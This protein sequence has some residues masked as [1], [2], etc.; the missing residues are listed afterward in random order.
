MYNNIK[1]F[2]FLKSK[3]FE[4]LALSR[5][6]SEEREK[7]FPFFDLPANTH[8]DNPDS[9]EDKIDRTLRQLNRYGKHL[10]NGFFYDHFDIDP[11]L[12]LRNGTHP[13]EYALQQ[14]DEFEIIPVIGLDR[15]TSHNDIAINHASINGDLGIRLLFEDMELVEDTFHDLDHILSRIKFI[16][17]QLHIFIDYRSEDKE[18]IYKQL[19]APSALLKNLKQAGYKKINLIVTTSSFPRILSDHVKTQ[20]IGRVP[21][22]EKSI[23]DKFYTKYSNDISGLGDYCTVSPEYVEVPPYIYQTIMTAKSIYTEQDYFFVTRGGKIEKYGNKQYQ[24]IAKKIISTATYR[25][26]VFSHGDS[27]IHRISTAKTKHGNNGSWLGISINCHLHYT[28]Q[29][30]I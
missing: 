1:Y 14:L 16:D 30:F 25:G 22:Y 13:Y 15:T 11:D 21:R 5:V 28:L 8:E 19:N 7:I 26:K 24:D 29:H 9:I 23:W 2:P 27:E 20:S 17:I 12:T 6:P 10:T 4:L 3:Q 18:N